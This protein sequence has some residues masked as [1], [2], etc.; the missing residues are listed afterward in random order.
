MRLRLAALGLALLALPLALAAPASADH[1]GVINHPVL[2]VDAN[3]GDDQVDFACHTAS[4]VGGSVT[5]H[6]CIQLSYSLAHSGAP[7]TTGIDTIHTYTLARY[8]CDDPS[9]VIVAC[10]GVS[11]SVGQDWYQ[12]GVGAESGANDGTLVNCGTTDDNPG[13]APACTAKKYGSGWFT[14]TSGSLFSN[15]DTVILKEASNHQSLKQ[16]E[17]FELSIDWRQNG[18]DRHPADYYSGYYTFS[19]DFAW[20][21]HPA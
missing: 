5:F 16:V 18:V 10:G 20:S 9:G 7:D 11:E 6:A 15:G 2:S 3:P 4:T 13:G 12:P 1:T 19:D 21:K 8:W 14:N 17:N